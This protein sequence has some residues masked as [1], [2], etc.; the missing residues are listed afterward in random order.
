MS[1]IVNFCQNCDFW[2]KLWFLVK[3]VIFGQN[4]DFWSKLWIFVKIVNFGQ[5]CD[6]W[7]KLWFLVKIVIFGENCEILSKLSKKN[8][9]KKKKKKKIAS[10]IL[11]LMPDQNLL[12]CYSLYF[13][14]FGFYRV[15]QR[16]TDRPDE[17][18]PNIRLTTAPVGLLVCLLA[19][20]GWATVYF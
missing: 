15:S 10:I 18:L 9:C 16:Q 20:L 14:P 12:R 13:A 5:H 11:K 7:S 19:W 6:F 1:K 2:S 8:F 4:C 3:I 17:K